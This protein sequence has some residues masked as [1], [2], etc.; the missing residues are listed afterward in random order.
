MDS[1][2]VIEA[3]EVAHTERKLIQVNTDILRVVS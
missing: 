1:T 2:E 3:T